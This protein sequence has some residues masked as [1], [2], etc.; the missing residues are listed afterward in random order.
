[1]LDIWGENIRNKKLTIKFF[2]EGNLGEEKTNSFISQLPSKA[3]GKIRCYSINKD[4]IIAAVN[5]IL[6][7][8]GNVLKHVARVW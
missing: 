6:P 1:M 8:A 7:R 5:Y 3:S 2:L 4:Q